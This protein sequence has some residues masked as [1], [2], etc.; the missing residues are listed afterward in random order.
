MEFSAKTVEEAVKNALTELSLS[1]D[2]V[3]IEIKEQ[4]TKGLFGK[5]KGK[6]VIEVTPKAQE[7]GNEEKAVELIENVLKYL[8]LDATATLTQGEERTVITLDS[9]SSSSLIGYRGEVLDAL[10]TLAGAMA[11][12]G[13]KVYK[14]VV[15]DCESYR[16]KRED[17]L[18]KLAKKLGLD[19]SVAI[20]LVVVQ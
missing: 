8:G 10:Q 18:I 7:K 12:I 5:L 4:P 9:E 6:A 2:Q 17:T 14:K 20:F 15:V 3:D 1:E 11:N 13:N 16:G 19:S